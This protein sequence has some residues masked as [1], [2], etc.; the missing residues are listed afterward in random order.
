MIHNNWTVL[1][2][3]AK[4]IN[5]IHQLA[6]ACKKYTGTVF[7][8]KDGNIINEQNDMNNMEIAL[9]NNYSLK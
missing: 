9:V 1:P 2:M 4:V 5:T 8:N 6:M 3:P 7:T